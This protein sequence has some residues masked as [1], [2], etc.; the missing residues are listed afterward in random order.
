MNQKGSD[1][2]GGDGALVA[3]FV[4][5][6]VQ[7][8]ECREIVKA[9]A[10]GV[11][12]AWAGDS[13]MKNNLS[14]VLENN[15]VKILPAGRE[16]VDKEPIISFLESPDLLPALEKELPA[17]IDD[18]LAAAAAVCRN[19][20]KAPA[21]EKM[22]LLGGILEN[23]DVSKLGE[24]ATDMARVINDIHETDPVF[25]TG[26]MEPALNAWI[27]RTD[28]GELKEALDNSF[29]DIV[30]LVASANSVIWQYP[31]KVVCVFALIPSVLNLSIGALNNTL[32]PLN[33]VA[34]ELLA[35]IVSSLIRS[36]R[37]EEIGRV[38]NESTE[39]VRKLHT[40]SALIGGSNNPL[41]TR[42]LVKLVTDVLGKIDVK[43]W[44][45]VKEALEEVKDSF[46]DM[47]ISALEN[48]PDLSK[49]FL[50][51]HFKRIGNVI[52]SWS[53]ETEALEDIF[54]DEDIAA[55]LAEV[56][57]QDLAD[58]INRVCTILNGAREQERTSATMTARF[59][60]A[61]DVYEVGETLK[62]LTGDFVQAAKPLAREVAPDVIRGVTELIRP[63]EDGDNSELK[64]ALAEFVQALNQGETDI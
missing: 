9:A 10:S 64:E 19:L 38:V 23:V 13:R 20:E 55:E 35:D 63:D 21:A 5:A 16:T 40:G 22:G 7:T 18:A 44:V 6:F 28:F 48:E 2:A 27:E 51:G 45:K 24:I 37:G 30:G 32:A 8:E 39:L 52:K 17:I 57:I 49:E 1:K 12:R 61:L 25:F 62:W 4:K 3:G 54:P 33:R 60:E 41:V 53:R 36:V 46:H 50:R 31:A 34:P 59:F 43:L 11:V 56:E 47:F 58:S 14:R 15:I 42:D 26:K 29:E